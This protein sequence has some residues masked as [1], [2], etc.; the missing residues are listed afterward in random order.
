MLAGEDSHQ[1]IWIFEW[2]IV[3]TEIATIRSLS[4]HLR[5]IFDFYIGCRGWIV[6]WK[7]IPIMRGRIPILNVCEIL[8]FR[9]SDWLFDWTR[10][11]NEQCQAE[12]L[13]NTRS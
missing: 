9:Q 1:R 4:R 5:T 3:A 13:L 10:D 11:Y 2:R 12:I 8:L 6:Y 7:R